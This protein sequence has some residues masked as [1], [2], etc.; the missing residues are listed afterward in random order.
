MNTF[1]LVDKVTINGYAN[2]SLDHIINIGILPST[3]GTVVAEALPII[4]TALQV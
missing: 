1:S 4:F 3:V 2:H